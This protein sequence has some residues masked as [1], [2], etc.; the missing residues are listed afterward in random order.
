MTDISEDILNEIV[1]LQRRMLNLENQ[2]NIVNKR[3]MK[4]QDEMVK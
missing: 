3:I 2:I 1:I 4:L